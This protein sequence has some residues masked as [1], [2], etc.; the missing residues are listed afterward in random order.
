M[1]VYIPFWFTLK[2]EPSLKNGARHIYT[3]IKLTRHLGKKYLNI[4]DPVISRNAYFAHP[5]NILLSMLSDPR[6]SVREKAVERIHARSVHNNVDVRY[7]HVFPINFE[8]TDYIEMS[9][10]NTQDITAPPILASVSSEE[11]LLGI[12]KKKQKWDF[13]DF[14]I[15]T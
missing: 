7:F 12:D 11:L 3:F 9:D 2:L 5:E 14:P 4:I 15:H 10:C 13:Y 1:E 6:K 8:A